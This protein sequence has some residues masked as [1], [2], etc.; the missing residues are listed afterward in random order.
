MITNQGMR[1]GDNTFNAYCGRDAH[2]GNDKSDHGNY[3]RDGFLA[4]LICNLIMADEPAPD[5]YADP[6][7]ALFDNLVQ[8]FA[9]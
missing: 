7:P 3:D 6:T 9:A 2:A 1:A 5:T 4:S 8:R